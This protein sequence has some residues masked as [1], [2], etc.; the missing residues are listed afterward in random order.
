MKRTF[1]LFGCLFDATMIDQSFGNG[2]ITF[3]LSI[4]PSG[5][6]N[7]HQLALAMTNPVPSL[8]RPY[9]RIPLSNNKHYYR[10]PI[11]LQKPILMTKY[12]FHDFIYRMSLSNRLK[13]AADYMVHFH[14]K[15]FLCFFLNFF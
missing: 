3:E 13:H 14:L 2:T 12:T 7:P 6:L 9:P 8:T 5:Y 15:N 1:V 10:L 4:G 11:D